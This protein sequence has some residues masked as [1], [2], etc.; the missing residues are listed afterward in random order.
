MRAD[1]ADE[2]RSSPPHYSL[3]VD[4]ELWCVYVFGVSRLSDSWM[5]QLALFGSDVRTAVVHVA[6]RSG[7]E[8]ASRDVVNLLRE[9]LRTGNRSTYGFLESAQ[10]A[11]SAR[12]A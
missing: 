10:L 8:A 7:V 12:G 1:L 2:M 5:V 4:G 9:W 11:P 3:V 6:A